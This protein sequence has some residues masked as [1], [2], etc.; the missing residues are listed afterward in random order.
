MTFLE[1][2]AHPV[3]RTIGKMWRSGRL[4]WR[5]FWN[6][7]NHIYVNARHRNL[8]D[9]LVAR[10]IVGLISSR[11]AAVLDYG[12][13]KATAAEMVASCCRSLIL[14]DAAPNTAFEV[15]ELVE[16]P[17]TRVVS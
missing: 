15:T 9:H 3:M 16:W 12:C 2:R 6:S 11:D 1:H 13:G 4:G 7:A 8:H 14:C 5:D 17:S 10:D